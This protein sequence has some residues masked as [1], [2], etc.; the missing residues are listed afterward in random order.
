ML[1]KPLLMGTAAFL[2]SAASASAS[3]ATVTFVEGSQED[4]D[5]NS[6][7]FFT[8]DI[9]G[10]SFTFQAGS[11][12]TNE[13]ASYLD[14]QTDSD[15]R[16]AT[17]IG[18]GIYA[19]SSRASGSGTDF[20]I[21]VAAGYTFDLTGFR[22]QGRE[23]TITA[24]YVKNGTT[25]S[26]T[27]TVG[28]DTATSFSGLTDLD[29]VT[30]VVLTSN[31]YALFQDLVITD[32]RGAGGTAPTVTSVSSTTAD[33]SY[34]AGSVISIQV[35]F[36]EAVTVTGTPQLFLET[37][38]VDRYI[39]YTGGSGTSSLTFSYTV[40][41]GANSADLDYHS[42]NALGL[43][44]GSIK[45]GADVSAA[46]TLPAPGA[47]GSLGFGKNII[48]DTSAPA[49]PA[50]PALAVGNDTGTS[51]TD[52]ITKINTPTFAGGGVSEANVTIEV[53]GSYT[54]RNGQS[55]TILV[56]TGKSD[57]T[58]NWTAS[59][60]T[61]LE[62]ATYSLQARSV[63]SA[64]NTSTLSGSRLVQIDATAPVAPTIK[65]AAG[66]DTG[67]SSSDGITSQS[68]PSFTGTAER[69]TNIQLYAAD[70]VTVLGSAVSSNS[71]SSTWSI[72]PST[73]LPEGTQT[74]TAKST[75]TAGNVSAAGTI[76]I[77]VDRTPP[78]APAGIALAAGEDTGVSATDGLT[79][80]TTPI[81]TGT[82]DAGTT[83]T[84]Y[85]TNGTSVLGSA[86][87]GAGGIW[88]IKSS[89]LTAG[90]HSLTAKAVDLA[91]NAS[92]SSGALAIT[93]DATAPSAPPA[94]VL[95][96]GSDTGTLG[97]G[98]TAVRTPRI[99]GT[100]EGSA[101]VTAYDTDEA[102]VIG[103]AVADSAG[104]WSIT[105]STLAAG[106]HTLKVRAAD[107]AG[108][109][110]PLSA[111]LQITVGAKPA[112]PSLISATPGDGEVTLSWTR[113]ADSGSEISG[114]LV[115]GSPQGSCTPAPVTATTCKV[116][117][118]SN[119]T[120]YSFTVAAITAAGT[121]DA[122]QPLS[123]TPVRTTA[124]GSLPGSSGS[125]SVTISQG[126]A[127]CTLT[128]SSFDAAAPAGIP[129]GATL[130]AGVFA[131]T[132][133][134]CPHDRLGISIQY[135]VALPANVRFMK[136]GPPSAGQPASWFELPASEVSLSSDRKT[137]A[138]QVT[139]N[140]AGDSNPA[141]G[142]IDDP[143]APVLLPLA[144][145][146][147]TTAIPAMSD[148]GVLVLSLLLLL[149]TRAKTSVSRR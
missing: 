63:D 138:Y 144:A 66:S 94:P 46:L 55:A 18:P 60:T 112:A 148:W 24:F 118:L 105:T 103:T 147:A 21:S 78:A 14:I 106:P 73:P 136:F 132:T 101:A 27:F 102:T 114:Y 92:A 88:S 124:S 83:V 32:V 36:S 117:G 61:K 79:S 91:G 4:L 58:G 133:D 20:S 19:L 100:A 69:I 77:T 31:N 47:A 72:L 98:I 67:I 128:S 135:P 35:N 96:A 110:S 70:G 16:Y 141:I 107:Q 22:T 97:D 30:A 90:M 5:G 113:P 50:I 143:F 11:A 8:R 146:A 43:N 93:V 52:R 131:F 120:R 111:G 62:D 59:A 75:D 29:D 1:L 71:T 9:L 129:A 15:P 122:S 10:A 68:L 130:P 86:V 17:G 81:V 74:L 57:G 140:Q 12:V 116:S 34:R 7:N 85:D 25:S 115:V 41:A 119:G 87:S 53:Y 109:R 149:W 127:A 80:V 42:V 104:N 26:K 125:A 76:T 23:T 48:L 40:Q 6:N 39:D 28:A 95:N 84:L 99:D 56:A 51:T 38:A 44:G 121:S 54:N 49:V 3:A 126:S 2:L 89:T 108:N 139:D 13:Q 142:R 137:V 37:G 134:G 145:P 33:G 65:V 82:A 45:N 123:A 64:G